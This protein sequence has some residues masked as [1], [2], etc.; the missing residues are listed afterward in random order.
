[1]GPQDPG[2]QRGPMG[3]FGTF[4]NEIYIE[5]WEDPVYIVDGYID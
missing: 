4:L 2:P 5:Y 3:G 1:M